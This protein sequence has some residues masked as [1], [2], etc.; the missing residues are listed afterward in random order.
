M[1]TPVS[2][3]WL[4]YQTLI[5]CESPS[6]GAVVDR[7]CEYTNCRFLTAKRHATFFTVIGPRPYKLLCSLLSPVKV[8]PTDKIYSEL[9]KKL[10]EHY[11]PAHPILHI[12]SS[13]KS[14]LPSIKQQGMHAARLALWK[15]S[16]LSQT[17]ARTMKSPVPPTGVEHRA[18][19][20]G[21]L[22]IYRIAEI[23]AGN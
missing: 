11:S 7:L 13:Y 8:K 9:V 10:T 3:A 15:Q 1:L 14:Q 12:A 20:L 22:S 5:S 21:W 18:C 23:L 6:Q 17:I 2:I 19:H 16:H 4:T